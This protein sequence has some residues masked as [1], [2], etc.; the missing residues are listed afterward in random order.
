MVLLVQNMCLGGALDRVTHE[1]RVL[2][3]S[4][5]QKIIY[6]LWCVACRLV[7]DVNVGVEELFVFNH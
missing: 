2:F 7:S 3:I 4:N 1:I 6:C 5:C